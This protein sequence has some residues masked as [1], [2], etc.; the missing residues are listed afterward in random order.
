MDAITLEFLRAREPHKK[1][2]GV[3]VELKACR[4]VPCC[5][6]W[7]LTPVSANLHEKSKI[8]LMSYCF[9]QLTVL[10]ACHTTFER[11]VYSQWLNFL[12]MLLYMLYN[13][14]LLFTT[15]LH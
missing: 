3:N 8:D 9:G 4:K 7:G 6:V 12:H 10:C 15:T 2:H 11:A 14:Y 5:K 13:F 1:T